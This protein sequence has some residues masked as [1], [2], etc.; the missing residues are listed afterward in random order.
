MEKY[1]FVV[2]SAEAVL[3]SAKL[4]TA[5]AAS[6]SVCS[7]AKPTA[8]TGFGIKIFPAID[9]LFLLVKISACF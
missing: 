9:D 3:K 5:S 6:Q 2:S 1:N 4:N 8:H 7:R